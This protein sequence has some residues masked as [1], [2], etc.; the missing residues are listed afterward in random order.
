MRSQGF[1]SRPL[2]LRGSKVLVYWLTE[3]EQDKNPIHIYREGAKDAR[4]DKR[5]TTKME[6]FVLNMRSQGFPSRPSRLRGSKVLVYWLIE[7]EQNKK[8]IHIYREGA[9][10]AKD[11]KSSRSMILI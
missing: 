11:V 2:R 8:P 1:P 10:D 3:K 7:K 9:K 4:D 5:R 6:V